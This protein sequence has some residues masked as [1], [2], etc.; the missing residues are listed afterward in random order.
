LLCACSLQL[1]PSSG[2]DHDFREPPSTN[3]PLGGWQWLHVGGDADRFADRRSYWN[4]SVTLGLRYNRTGGVTRNGYNVSGFDA[5]RWTAAGAEGAL[6]HVFHNS[7]WGN[8]QFRVDG[9]GV[10][11]S[12]QTVR[13][14]A[15]G[16]GWQEG[17]GG[18]MGD[19][20]FFVEG[21]REALDAPEEWWVDRAARILYFMPNAT[22]AA[23]AGAAGAA[24]PALEVVAPRLRTLVALRGEGASE[25]I[26]ERGGG[27]GGEPAAGAEHV[28]GVRFHGVAFAH[29][30]TR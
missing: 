9:A 29:T 4:G 16:G 5:S 24:A 20:P 1:D 21:V 2:H 6:A 30:A 17:H 7:Y 3:N 25:R 23:T 13:F 18:V 11:S 8:W 15:E 27:A 28:V 14:R 22:T 12:A 19:Q 26:P 10:N